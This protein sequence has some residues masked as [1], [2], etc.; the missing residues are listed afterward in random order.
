LHSSRRFCLHQFQGVLD[1]LGGACQV[2]F[3]LVQ[4]RE[5]YVV[6]QLRITVAAQGCQ[7]DG[8]LETRVGLFKLVPLIMDFAQLA[9]NG[10]A[11]GGSTPE[12]STRSIP[13]EAISKAKRSWP[14]CMVIKP[15]RKYQQL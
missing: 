3:D 11:D 14:R 9:V 1:S 6:I 15:N 5:D 12:R 7:L 8:T 2:A 4:A 10:L 13:C